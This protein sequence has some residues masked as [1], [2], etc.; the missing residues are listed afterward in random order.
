MGRPVALFLQPAPASTG[1]GGRG[2]PA[3]SSGSR[4]AQGEIR[5]G[6]FFFWQRKLLRNEYVQTEAPREEKG[7]KAVI[8]TS[9][10]FQSGTDG[11]LICTLIVLLLCLY[12]KCLLSWGVHTPS[13]ARFHIRTI[14]PIR[15]TKHTNSPSK[16]HGPTIDDGRSQH[17]PLLRPPLFLLRPLLPSPR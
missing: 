14:L 1:G 12:I 2:G 6:V 10:Q 8:V 9:M 7:I 16:S 13:L 11:T 15:S 4:S 3:R 5:A 17:G